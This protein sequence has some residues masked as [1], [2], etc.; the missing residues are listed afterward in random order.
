MYK[1]YKEGRLSRRLN[2]LLGLLALSCMIYIGNAGDGVQVD[3][4][5]KENVH[6]SKK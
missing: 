6:V 4:P 2:V 5:K 3:N 1:L